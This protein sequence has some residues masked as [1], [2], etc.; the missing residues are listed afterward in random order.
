MKNKYVMIRGHAFSEENDMERLKSYA[1]EGWILEDIKGVF[2]YKLR[3]DNPQDIEYC[4]DYQMNPDEEYFTIFKEAGW[5]LVVSMQNYTHIFSA[6]AGTKPIY[7]DGVSEIDKYTHIR[8]LTKKGTIYSSIIAIILIG[9]SIV[10][11]IAIRPI[12]LVIVG[13]FIIDLFV[14][15]FNFMPYLSYNYR[16]RQIREYGKCNGKAINNKANSKTSAFAGVIFLIAGI[17]ELLDK[18]YFGILLII[19]GVL[20]IIACLSYYKKYKKSL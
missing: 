15:T 4:L 14:F 20:N 11:L 17:F 2:F 3:K 12:F 10:S 18:S 8:N 9:L 19:A 1:S 7:S 13:L 6:E 16:I 5:K